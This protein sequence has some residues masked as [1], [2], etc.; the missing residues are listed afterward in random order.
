MLNKSLTVIVP[1]PEVGALCDNNCGYCSMR[2]SNRITVFDRANDDYRKDYVNKLNYAREEGCNNLILTG[3]TTDPLQN[4]EWLVSFG[5]FLSQM[6][7][8]FRKIEFRTMGSG[9]DLQFFQFLKELGVTTLTLVCY[10]IFDDDNNWSYVGCGEDKKINI[11]N[12][13]AMGRQ[14]SIDVRLEVNLTE[15]YNNRTHAEVLS[16]CATLGA[17]QVTFKGLYYDSAIED[18]NNEWLREHGVLKTWYD[19]LIDYIEMNGVVLHTLETG[20]T[21]Y[22]CNGISIVLKSLETDRATDYREEFAILREDIYLYTKWNT[23]ASK[24]L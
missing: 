17:T 16:K 2:N 13:I 24:I 8:P 4:K 6:D 22:D 19:T 3:N 14:T 23:L 9:L 10:D 7:K 11:A 18:A 5:S 20:L 15:D 1:P 12:V 21:Q